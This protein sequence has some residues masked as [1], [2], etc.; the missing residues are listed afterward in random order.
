MSITPYTLTNP[1][2]VKVNNFDMLYS[3]DK[4]LLKTVVLIEKET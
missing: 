4:Q 2:N 1:T 3:D